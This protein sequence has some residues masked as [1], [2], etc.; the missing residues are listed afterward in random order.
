M[1]I[2]AKIVPQRQSYT[3]KVSDSA[4]VGRLARYL[5]Q[6][7]AFIDSSTLELARPVQAA[8]RLGDVDI[9]AGDRLLVFASK[10]ASAELPAPL[11]PGDKVMKFVLGDTVV[12]SRGKKSL[13]IGKPDPAREVDIDLRSFI[14]PKQLG[15]IS[16][17]TLRLDFDERSKTWYA[18]RLGRT[19][20]LINEYE[21]TA[22]PIP[23]GD[24]SLLRLYRA[25]EEP[26]NPAFRPLVEIQLITESVQ[27]RE[28]LLYLETG[29]RVLPIQVGVEKDSASLNVSD[30]VLFGQ[31]LSGLTA[32][33]KLRFD[34]EASLYLLRLLPPHTPLS[35]VT[36]GADEFLYAAR[37]QA[38][39]MN[40]LI[41]RDLASSERSYELTAGPEDDVKLIGRRPEAAIE[42]PEL[43]VDLYH[44]LIDRAGNP[45]SFKGISRRQLR[46]FYRAAENTW[47]AQAEERASV[48]VFVNNTRCG[49]NTPVQLTSGDVISIGASVDHYV[50]RLEVEI[51]A[52]G[53]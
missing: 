40:V 45:G 23:L 10:P 17:D 1:R 36:L 4:L 22:D 11:N 29:D 49:A 46:V 44:S 41:L 3:L 43:D 26:T 48:P 31:V 27:S 50:A 5:S 12:S 16:R 34:A 6:Q 8:Q 53:G 38:F 28:D 30:N 39:A 37:A 14:S 19:R 42:D 18:A 15:Y 47:W 24:R 35:Q 13:L 52:K 21:L 32:H 33:L 51:T 25:N 20:L 7:E 2:L 9:Q